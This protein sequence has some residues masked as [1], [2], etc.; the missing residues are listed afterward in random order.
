MAKSSKSVG[1]NIGG[2]SGNAGDNV[3]ADFGAGNDDGFIVIDPV[4]VGTDFGN[5]DGSNGTG[6]STDAGSADKPKRTYT[7]RSGT[8]TSKSKSALDINGVENILFSMH[9]MLAAITSTPELALDKTEAAE[10]AKAAD[11]VAQHY[12]VTAS[13]KTLAW[14]NLLMVVGAAYGTRIF[15]IRIRRENERKKRVAAKAETSVG[16]L[17]NFPGE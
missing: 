12:D 7:K 13:A 8:G 11:A 4:S 1:S 17:I 6:S 15:A 9:T 2:A 3:G 14:T 10:I 5:S 16:N